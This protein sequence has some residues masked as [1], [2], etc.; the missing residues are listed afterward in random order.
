M[1]NSL[2]PV[3]KLAMLGSVLGIAILFIVFAKGTEALSSVSYIGMAAI[4]LLGCS[5]FSA[6]TAGKLYDYFQVKKPLLRFVPCI[7]ELS[8]IDFKLRRIA[9]GFYCGAA[10]LGVLL[11]TRLVPGVTA[12]FYLMLVIMALLSAVQV[13]K[14]IGLRATYTELEADWI[15]ISG[16]S[17]G[18]LKIFIL[19]GYIPFVR[20]YL[21][22]CINKILMT[23][24]TFGGYN[25]K[26]AYAERDTL[27][28]AEDK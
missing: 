14:G 2:K 3:I 24:V 23:L 9:L 21:V 12:P 7:G 13:V 22:Y 16:H 8:L 19:L 11:A 26:D 20:V 10:F 17:A 27:D 28:M 1:K 4:V 6:I 18:A 15:K 25:F 5:F